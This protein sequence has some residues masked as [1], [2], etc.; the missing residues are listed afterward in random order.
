MDLGEELGSIGGRHF[1]SDLKDCRECAA[2]QRFL[3][4]FDLVGS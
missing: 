2:A 3:L 4:W 1:D